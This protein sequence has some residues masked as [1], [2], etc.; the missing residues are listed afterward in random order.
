MRTRLLWIP[1]AAL[2]GFSFLIS[3]QVLAGDDIRDP[4][5]MK[6]IAASEGLISLEEAKQKALAVKPGTI[7]ANGLQGG[8]TNWKS[9]MPM[10]LNGKSTSTPKPAKFVN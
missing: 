2:I 8:T 1:T 3:G 4:Q 5:Q 10:A 7:V 9:S 6:A